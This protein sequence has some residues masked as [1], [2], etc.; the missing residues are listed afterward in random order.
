MRGARK[1]ALVE[2][3]H[4]L[5]ALILGGG[6]AAIYHFFAEAGYRRHYNDYLSNVRR[7]QLLS[8]GVAAVQEGAARQNGFN[9]ALPRARH[10]DLYLI[11]ASDPI[12]FTAQHA[13]KRVFG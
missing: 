3:D 8:K 5:D 1:I 13:R 7:N 12:F 2:H 10:L 11:S 4:G 6:E 9:H